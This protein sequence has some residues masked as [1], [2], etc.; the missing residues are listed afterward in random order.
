MYWSKSQF[1]KEPMIERKKAS[2]IAREGP[3]QPDVY[4]SPP[5]RISENANLVI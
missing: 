3:G 5:R 4:T 2:I 1:P